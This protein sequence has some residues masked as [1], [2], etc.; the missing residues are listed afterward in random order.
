MMP[1]L[2][3]FWCVS[4]LLLAS[5]GA[6]TTDTRPITLVGSTSGNSGTNVKPVAEPPTA[7]TV[8]AIG[9]TDVSTGATLNINRGAPLTILGVPVCTT[10]PGKVY[11]GGNGEVSIQPTAQDANGREYALPEPPVPLAPAPPG[12]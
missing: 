7:A 1:N 12:K 3:L 8:K 10:F 11:V 5:Q 6:R 2:M 9:P 4:G